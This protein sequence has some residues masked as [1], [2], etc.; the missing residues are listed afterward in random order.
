LLRYV[1]DAAVISFDLGENAS[2]AVK[3]L[4]DTKFPG[5]RTLICGDAREDV[6]GLVVDRGARRTSY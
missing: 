2:G 5:R 1:P 6:P 3:K 4:L